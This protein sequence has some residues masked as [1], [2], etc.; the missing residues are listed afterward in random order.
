M[1]IYFSG[2]IIVL[3]KRDKRNYQLTDDMLSVYK[4]K[5]SQAYKAELI[6]ARAE[7]G[8]V[9]EVL[10]ARYL[11]LPMFITRKNLVKMLLQR[12]KYVDDQYTK[13]L[14]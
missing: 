3:E 2:R 1:K 14:R 11:K 8:Q 4:L 6:I 12:S 7:V 5:I 9:Y 10:K 13:S